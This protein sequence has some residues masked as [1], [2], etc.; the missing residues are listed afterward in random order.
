MVEADLK[1][2]TV[3]A[4]SLICLEEVA[5]GKVDAVRVRDKEVLSETQGRLP[6]QPPPP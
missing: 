2:L 5:R 4:A 6:P 3:A 1:G